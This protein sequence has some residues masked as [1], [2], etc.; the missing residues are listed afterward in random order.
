[1]Q[2]SVSK[3]DES[4]D[5]GLAI[6]HVDE[7]DP[8]KSLSNDL[9]TNEPSDTAQPKDIEKQ[10]EPNTQQ[11]NVIAGEDYS[12][13]TVPQK[14]AIIVAGSFLAWFSPVSHSSPNP[15][16]E[17]DFVDGSKMTGSIYYPALNQ[18]ARDLNTSSSKINITVTTYLVGL[19][20]EGRNEEEG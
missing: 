9:D 6:Q 12:V 4:D 16:T 8:E 10:E 14:R 13:F 15:T 11:H 3:E 1:M 7:K 19:C 20:C 17:T 18:I 5:D 2:H